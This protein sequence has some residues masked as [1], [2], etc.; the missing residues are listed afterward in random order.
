LSLEECRTKNRQPANG[1]GAKRCLNSLTSSGYELGH[2]TCI[3]KTRFKSSKTINSL[4]F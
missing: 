4:V 3:I 1:I 2:E